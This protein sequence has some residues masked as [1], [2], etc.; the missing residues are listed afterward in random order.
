MIDSKKR[1]AAGGLL[2]ALDEADAIVLAQVQVADDQADVR[3]GLEAG[4][5][6]LP[7]GAGHA[8]VATVF[9]QFAKF[10]G[11]LGFVIDDQHAETPRGRFVHGHTLHLLCF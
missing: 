2:E 3:V 8:T 9:Q 10:R 7:V 6:R 4:D 1:L 5:G 11:H